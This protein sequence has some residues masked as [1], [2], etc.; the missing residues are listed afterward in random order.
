MPAVTVENIL[1]GFNMEDPA[2]RERGYTKVLEAFVA[3][4]GE[5]VLATPRSKFPWLLPM[6]AAVGALGLLVF[7]GRRWVKKGRADTA[8]MTAKT[9]VPP[10]DKYADKLDDE[11]A[12]TD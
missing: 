2:D 10:E 8:A 1:A 12:E 6:L 3:D 5:S 4:Y 9:N 7:A 11:L